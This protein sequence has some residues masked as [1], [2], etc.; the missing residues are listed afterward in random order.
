LRLGR[1]ADLSH[2]VQYRNGVART[3]STGFISG[4]YGRWGKEQKRALALAAVVGG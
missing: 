2:A 3:I 4:Y 1:T